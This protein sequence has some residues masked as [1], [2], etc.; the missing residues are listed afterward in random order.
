ME[1]AKEKQLP[2]LMKLSE[3]SSVLNQRPILPINLLKYSVQPTEWQLGNLAESMLC[4]LNFWFIRTGCIWLPTS[5]ERV[6]MLE[7]PFPLYL[8]L[9]EGVVIDINL[10]RSLA[11]IATAIVWKWWTSPSLVE[12]QPIVSNKHE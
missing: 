10:Q 3:K 9:K 7:Y 6:E 11:L 8:C 12:I 1:S 4:L 5:E 2:I